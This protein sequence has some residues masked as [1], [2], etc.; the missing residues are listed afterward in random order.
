[1]GKEY[2][3][4]SIHAK[5]KYEYL[6]KMFDIDDDFIADFAYKTMNPTEEL[7]KWISSGSGTTRSRM[8]H[9][10]AVYLPET[11]EIKI[12]SKREEWEKT[13]PV[14]EKYKLKFLFKKGGEGN[15]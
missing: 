2:K 14:P 11:D 12:V 4:K 6:K 10:Y 13:I 7:N 9:F 5:R 15:D 1:M 8:A 3:W